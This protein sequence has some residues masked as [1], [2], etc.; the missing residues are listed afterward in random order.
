MIESMVVFWVNNR[1]F[2]LFNFFREQ[3]GVK[4][5]MRKEDMLDLCLSFKEQK[6]T[7]FE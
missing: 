1:S 4:G 3:Y 7:G 6:I 2:D 5:P